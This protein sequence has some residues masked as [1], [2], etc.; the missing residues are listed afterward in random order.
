VQSTNARKRRMKRYNVSQVILLLLAISIL[1]TARAIEYDFEPLYSVPN[2]FL[3][4]APSV[5]N[6]GTVAYTVPGHSFP[7]L[8][9]AGEALVVDDGTEIE[10][11]DLGP[12]GRTLLNQPLINDSQ[13]VAVRATDSGLGSPTGGIFLVY[14]PFLGG[15]E[16]VVTSNRDNVSGDFREIQYFALNNNNQVAALVTLTTG[17]FAIIRADTGGYQILDV[18]NSTQRFN[19]TR[20]SINDSGVVAYK[21]QTADSFVDIYVADG[22]N[23]PT[24][25][26]DL[27][28]NANSGDGPDINDSGYVAAGNV[29]SLVIGTDGSVTQVVVDGANSPFSPGKGPTLVDLNSF[30]EVVFSA[31]SNS[32][33]GLFFGDDAV[34]DK[35]IQS[36]DQLF[37]ETVGAVLFG[38]INGFNDPRQVVFNATTIDPF[39]NQTS[40]IVLATPLSAPPG[41]T[42]ADGVR[43]DLD[44]CP[45]TANSDQADTDANGI[46]D[47]CDFPPPV[48]S[49]KATVHP[50]ARIGNGSAIDQGATISSGVII[51]N[52]TLIDRN[53]SIG[54]GAFIG[55]RVQIDRGV[56]V[57]AGVEIGDD[58]FIGRNSRIG[59]NSVIGS[60]AALGQ[61]VIVAPGANV[62]NDASVP[63]GTEVN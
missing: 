50:S 12:I 4:S 51:G 57:E 35:L 28:S 43:D 62:P 18:A 39:G 30:N 33:S 56:V 25:A 48:I 1:E 61:N 53:V 38:G 23:P 6:H 8:E 29:S 21:A 11:Y 22:V 58:V 45:T 17:Q 9:L 27:P 44:N 52:E 46:G 19:F 3:A 47:A 16:T 20:P 49:S 36:G 32:T 34:G 10:I 55:D 14:G 63:A 13:V 5:N 31:S 60:G 41:D 7:I 24:K 59:T 15:H 42:D 40:H 2:T 37:G 54:V 26:V